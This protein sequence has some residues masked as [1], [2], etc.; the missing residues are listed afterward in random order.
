MCLGYEASP[1]QSQLPA[2][3]KNGTT[4]GHSERPRMRSENDQDVFRY[5]SEVVNA[6]MHSLHASS[7]TFEERRVLHRRYQSAL[8]ALRVV[9]ASSSTSQHI[10]SS[11]HALALYEVRE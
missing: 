4:I 1:A 3:A 9:V 5:L 11:A 10:A 7:Q 8:C 2:L 6:G